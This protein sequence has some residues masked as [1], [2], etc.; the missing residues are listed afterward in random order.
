MSWILYPILGGIIGYI[1][2]D[3]AIWMLFH[4]YKA[5]RIGNFH[6][7]FTPGII[8]QQKNRIAEAI[9]SMVS[10]HLFDASTLRNALLSESMLEKVR[11][12]VNNFL[13]RLKHD[14]RTLEQAALALNLKHDRIISCFEDNLADFIL[15]RISQGQIGSYISG[16]V[17]DEIRRKL[18]I[19]AAEKI[20]KLG[21][22]NVIGNI[23]DEKIRENL[24]DKIRSEIKTMGRQIISLRLTDIFTKNEKYSELLAESTTEIYCSVL[25]QN[26]DKILDGINFSEIVVQKIRSFSPKELEELVFGVMKKELKAVVHL[27]ALL[28]FVMG[29]IN[30][31]FTYA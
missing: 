27:G 4:P 14:E 3:I 22:V 30:I 18:G 29:F 2:N 13:E 6:V 31:L 24:R 5:V 11:T 19:F 20:S 23:I 7:P 8:P 25:E 9:G 15:E 1:T 16:K 21:I 28:G 12:R 10:R 17:I 26:I